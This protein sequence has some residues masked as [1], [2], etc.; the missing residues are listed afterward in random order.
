M[1]YIRREVVHEQFQR[2]GGSWQCRF[3]QGLPNKS[4]ICCICSTLSLSTQ[5][6]AD[7]QTS[8]PDFIADYDPD[9]FKEEEEQEEQ[10]IW[11]TIQPR[12]LAIIALLL[13]IEGKIK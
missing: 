6:V 3:D 11:K 4:I 1:F 13:V 9:Q 10:E 5:I 12:G 2:T 7:I 8:E